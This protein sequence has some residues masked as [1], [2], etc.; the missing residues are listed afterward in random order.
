MASACSRARWAARRTCKAIDVEQAV[1]VGAID[2]RFRNIRVK[3]PAGRHSIG[4]TYKQ[5]TA[6]E[7]NEV[8][9]GFVPVVGMGQ[10]VNGNSGGPRI[11]NVEIKGPLSHTG[12][13][14]T[15]SRRKLLVCKPASA[16]QETPCAQQILGTLA[17][18]AY[19]R[20]V[21]DADL[22]GPD[23]LLRSGRKQG[24]FDDGIQKG[25]MAMLASP[26]FL[27]RFHT[28]PAGDAAGPGL[29]AQ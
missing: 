16:A 21:T 8:L 11:S 4:V 12:V 1:G 15:P 29:R 10:M 3:V 23:G 13:S 5:K 22:A 6:A 24:T 25:V 19:R 2:Q 27:Y 17:K 18:R 20:P 14:D 9:H 7:H 26:K 28:P